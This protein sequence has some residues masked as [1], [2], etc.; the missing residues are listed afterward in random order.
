MKEGAMFELWKSTSM[1]KMSFVL[2]HPEIVTFTI[3]VTILGIKMV[4]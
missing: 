3:D 1:S 4:S 2:L